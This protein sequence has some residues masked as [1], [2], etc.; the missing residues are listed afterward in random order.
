MSDEPKREKTI[1]EIIE[2][3]GA[4]VIEQVKR[5]VREGNVRRVKLHAKDGDIT[6][7]M[8]MTIGVVAGGVV[9]LAA[10]WLAILGV[11]AALVAHIQL[12]VE[13]VAEPAAPEPA[14]PAEEAAKP[15]M[16]EA[17]GDDAG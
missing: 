14:A 13:R 7:E 8:P 17:E 11:I 6:L 9:A 3:S 10:P 16:A 15:E 1:I 4:E 5:I 2:V 12:E